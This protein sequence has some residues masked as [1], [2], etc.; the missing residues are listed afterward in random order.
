MNEREAI[1][2]MLREKPEL[3]DWL[4]HLQAT[5]R[6]ESSDQIPLDHEL[7]VAA[8]PWPGNVTGNKQ[9]RCAQCNALCVIAPSTQTMMAERP[10]K[11]TIKCIRC[12]MQSV[13]NQTKETKDR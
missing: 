4:L 9:V 3:R 13:A 2:K 1:R 11:T 7:I 6:L 5:D 12:L 10:G 8:G